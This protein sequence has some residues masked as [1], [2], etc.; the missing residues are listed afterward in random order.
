MVTEWE[1]DGDSLLIFVWFEATSCKT[2]GYGVTAFDM[3]IADAYN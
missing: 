1:Q 3:K 2:V